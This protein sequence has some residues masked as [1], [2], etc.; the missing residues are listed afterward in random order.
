MKQIEIFKKKFDAELLSY[1]DTKKQALERFDKKGGEIIE[2]LE[3]FLKYGGKRFRPALFYYAYEYFTKNELLDSVQFSFIFELFHTFALIH[4]DIIDH[5]ILRRGNPTIHTKYGLHMG[6][7]SG[8]VAL[9]LADELYLKSISQSQ[10]TKA[11]L[12]EI[13]NF[14][15][16]YK[17]ELLVGQ[18]LDC[19]HLEDRKKIMKL[20]TANYSFVKPVLFALL[21]AKKSAK[22][23]QEWQI[24]LTRLGINFQLKD[25]YEGVFGEEKQTGK[26]FFSDTEEGKNTYIVELFKKR[27]SNKELKLF[28]SFF[29]KQSIPPSIFVEYLKLLEEKH[30]KEDIEFKIKTECNELQLMLKQKVKKYTLFYTLLQEIIDYINTF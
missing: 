19:I 25:D 13:N 10:F 20:K 9:T 8:D 29:G 18:Y 5:S 12:V 23:K 2:S 14:F 11:Q 28:N 15:N 7:L 6:I 3:I 1:L 17:Q 22:R 27:A 26:L 16:E 21:F 30:I 24:F 4:D